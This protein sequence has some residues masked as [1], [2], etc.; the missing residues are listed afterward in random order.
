MTERQAV[1]TKTLA[2]LLLLSARRVQQL[3]E[4]GIFQRARDPAT[5]QE[6]KGRYRLRE[7]V[8]AYV[9]Y[10]RDNRPV[11]AAEMDYQRHRSRR[12]SALADIEQ[13][14][15]KTA[16]WQAAS[17][18]GRRVRD[19]PDVDGLQEQ[20]AGF[21]VKVRSLSAGKDQCRGDRGDAENGSVRCVEGAGRL[22]SDKV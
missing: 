17:L 19:D 14:R 2:T 6:L 9:V 1:S 8:S 3:T 12:M 5:G 4:G 15:L 13:L 11:D 10:L 16:S 7:S 18:R 22:R 20:D 21:T